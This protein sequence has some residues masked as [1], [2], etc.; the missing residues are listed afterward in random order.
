MIMAYKNRLNRRERE[1]EEIRKS[2]EGFI[3]PVHYGRK[4][5]KVNLWLWIGVGVLIFLLLIWLTVAMF[6]GDTDVNMIT[7]W[8]WI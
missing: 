1:I 3:P 2:D 8:P 7:P 6:R 4:R 5:S